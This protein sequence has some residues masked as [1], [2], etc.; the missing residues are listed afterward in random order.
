MVLLTIYVGLDAII[1]RNF[2]SGS[3]KERVF[4]NFFC[5]FMISALSLVLGSYLTL[6]F[7]KFVEKYGIF[8]NYLIYLISI[9][10]GELSEVG[11]KAMLQLMLGICS[12]SIMLYSLILSC[13]KRHLIKVGVLNSN[14]LKRINSYT[15]K[16]HL[17]SIYTVVIFWSGF[18][19]LFA[20]T[21]GKPEYAIEVR[22]FV[23]ITLGFA[24]PYT[25]LIMA[26]IF[27][28]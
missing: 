17:N 9:T 8:N 3:F 14:K 13:G 4:F 26:K 1:D 21:F 22:G 25:H 23:S 28:R 7:L 16:G 5:Q 2:L 18:L 20:D 27:E 11:G 6:L 15:V 10:S 12:I 19:P 24:I